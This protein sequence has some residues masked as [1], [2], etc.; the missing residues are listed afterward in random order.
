MSCTVSI[1]PSGRTIA[2]ARGTSLHDAL[3]A[4]GE[5]LALPCGDQG[6]CGR[7]LVRI[8][9]DVKRR[10]TARLSAEQ[11]AQGWA[12]ACQ[13]TVEGDLRVIV[14]S[15]EELLARPEVIA[16]AEK[17]AVTA[18]A[19]EHAA[20]PWVRALRLTIDA[21][22]LE[23]NT[24]DWE[25]LQREFARQ[26]GVRGVV[27]S[28]RVLRRLAATLRAGD[29]TVTAVLARGTWLEPDAPPRLLD[30][31]PGDATGPSY[32]VAIDI[33]TTSVVVYL[34]NLASRA[35]VDQAAAYNGQIA[36]GE[37][38]ISRIIYARRN[39][40]L[41]RLRSLVVETINALLDEVYQRQG[42]AAEDVY[43]ATV[44]G[45]PTMLHLFLGL[46][47]QFIRL[48]PY[49]P[50][51]NH[52]VPVRAAELGLRLNPEAVVD[53]LPG[54]GAYVGADIT[55]GLLRSEM[56]E[57]KALTLFIDVG[58]NGEIVLGNS[59]WLMACACS[60][61]PAFEGAGVASGMRAAPG[62]IEEVWIDRRTAEPTLRTIGD[63]PPKGICG[64]GMISLLGELFVTGVVDKGGRLNRDL[65][66]PRVRLGDDGPEYVLAWAGD[67]NDG[68]GSQDGGRDRNNGRD[69]VLT[70]A[71]IQNLIRAKGA[72][73]AGFSVLTESVGLTLDDVERIVIGG[74]FGKYIDVEKAVAI[75][76]L[77]DVPWER[78]EYLGNTSIQ[79]AY[80]A[81][82][83]R[84]CRAAVTGI[85]NKMTYLELSA[86][87]RFMEQFT[88]ALF[89]PH[90][91]LA[92]FPSVKRELARLA[93]PPGSEEGGDT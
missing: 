8:E 42:I 84:E 68:S 90:T 82:L 34:A 32:G 10:S 60:A 58:T 17:A 69:I 63:T 16:G 21:P 31:R 59:D 72:I 46:D 50:T 22:T 66:T 39:G 57:G 67:S 19:C 85:G 12:L 20:E 4:A 71:D 88:S 76:L 77:P 75:G 79:G 54:V 61:G 51:V 53:C 28:L 47:P 15:Q 11:V 93:A 83:C 92:S 44:A 9:G 37:D 74:A 26:H 25:R 41:E 56:H 52:P 70:E 7:C 87:N 73:Y 78:F 36:C 43:W 65:D 18:Q 86:D 6:R 30:L 14:P 38:V 29:W 62:A 91:D 48:D 49:I 23:D 35:L 64:S 81:L 1:H 27:A 45:N 3:A 33:G 13:T 2:V 89:L 55:A 24:T 80:R 5:G 40:G